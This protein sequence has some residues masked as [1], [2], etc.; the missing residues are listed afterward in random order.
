MAV[1]TATRSPAL[2]DVPTVGETVA[3]YE[4]AGWAGMAAPKGTPPEI[5]DKLNREIN[6]GLASRDIKARYT[7]MGYTMFAGS[8]AEFGKFI[9]EDTERWGKVI[10]AANIKPE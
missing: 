6:A 8:A 7:E 10:R 5:I 4:A 9:A 3:G 1:T 2:P